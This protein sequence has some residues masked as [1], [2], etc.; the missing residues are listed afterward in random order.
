MKQSAFTIAMT[1]TVLITSGSWASAVEGP[2]FF[3]DGDGRLRLLSEKNGQIF[4]G[5]YRS[6]G[7]RYDETALKAIYRVFG[8][9]YDPAFPRLSLRLIAF[10]DFLED[11][12]QPGAQITVTSGYRSPEYNTNVR[13]RGGLAA[14][15]SL[16]QYGMAADIVMDGV[17]S[18]RV[19]QM[20]K[21]VG[22]GGAGYYHGRTVH[23]DVGPARSWDEK[24]SG[25]GTGISDD[26]KLVG[27]VT[28]F[29]VYRPGAKMTLRFIRM[30][31]FPIG[32]VPVFS[33][34]RQTRDET[35]IEV[36]TF[37]PIFAT[38]INGA[39]PQ[40]DDI[41]QMAAIGWV[42]PSELPAGHY[43]IR[44]RFCGRA[45]EAM[46]PEV[47]TPTFEVVAP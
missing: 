36:A 21:S 26:N 29:D 15:A 28:D 4:E 25:V 34:N 9:S 5:V 22:F 17:P 2:R 39:C 41:E 6:A 20:V 38:A 27:M 8:A 1:I 30:T 40:F 18:E 33:L 24:T 35:V 42:L 13:K 47:V 46:P 14:K 7:G 10:L 31:A 3:H 16:H 37:K 32:V 45:W 12:L 44:A 43:A 11:R 19:W 23:V